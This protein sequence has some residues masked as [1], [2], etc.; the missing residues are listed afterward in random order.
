MPVYDK[1]YVDDCVYWYIYEELKKLVFG[2][3]WKYIPCK[4][5]RIFTLV[6][7]H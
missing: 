1:M 6:Y 3:T 5:P 4:L 7:V 2:Y